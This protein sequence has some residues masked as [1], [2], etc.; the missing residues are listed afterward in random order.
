MFCDLFHIQHT[1]PW[2]CFLLPFIQFVPFSNYSS[3][4]SVMPV[5]SLYPSLLS[6]VFLFHRFYLFAHVILAPT[7]CGSHDPAVCLKYHGIYICII[8]LR[9]QTGIIGHLCWNNISLH[10]ILICNFPIMQN[11]CL[12]AGSPFCSSSRQCL[13]Y[14]QGVWGD[15]QPCGLTHGHG[16]AETVSAWWGS[17][18]W[19]DKP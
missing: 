17:R 6:S 4:H 8:F 19:R 1:I 14:S 10:C 3:F 16:C 9:M 2:F 5:V 18:L 11:W 15:T 12:V 13:L 7:S